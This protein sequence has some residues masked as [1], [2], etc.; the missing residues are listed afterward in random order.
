MP[1][2]DDS[3]YISLSL[4]DSIQKLKSAKALLMASDYFLED[5]N[6]LTKDSESNYEQYENS[7]YLVSVFRETFENELLKLDENITLLFEELKRL[8][9]QRSRGN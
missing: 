7:R 9:S 8:R 4:Q 3:W 5:V 6:Y 1:Q 2:K